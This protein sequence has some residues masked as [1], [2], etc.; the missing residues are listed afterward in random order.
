MPK[1]NLELLYKNRWTYS[2]YSLISL[3]FIFRKKRLSYNQF[4]TWV[5]MDFEQPSPYVIKLATLKRYGSSNEAWVETGTFRGQTTRNLASMAKYVISIE[6]S[7][8]LYQ[9]AISELRGCHNVELLHGTSEEKLEWAIQKIQSEGYNS[10]SLWLDGHYSAGSTYKGLKDSP[11]IYELQVVERALSNFENLTV[12][13]DDVRCFDPDNPI[14]S[15]YPNLSYLSNWAS[16]LNLKWT[17]EFD[18][19]IARKNP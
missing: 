19:F 5:K 3:I 2:V 17:I 4:L 9:K 7:D 11:I 1:H 6:P 18:I 14:F 15:D 8:I 12:L 10:L 16:R 13:V